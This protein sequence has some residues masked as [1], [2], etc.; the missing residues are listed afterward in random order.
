L[1]STATDVARFCQMIINGGVYEGK[2]YLSAPA[3]AQM[4]TRQTAES[5]KEGYGLGWA[6]GVD[7]YGHSGA[8]GTKMAIDTKRGVITAFLVQDSGSPRSSDKARDAFEKAVQGQFGG[9]RQ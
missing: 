2:R 3:V 8:Y 7:T 6:I 4:T 9:A 5:I 1:F